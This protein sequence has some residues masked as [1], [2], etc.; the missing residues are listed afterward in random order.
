MTDIMMGG[1]VGYVPSTVFSSLHEL[2]HYV[3]TTTICF[4]SSLFYSKKLRLDKI[5]CVAQV[6]ELINSGVEI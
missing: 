3:F 4:I 6:V 2:F 1:G 5:K